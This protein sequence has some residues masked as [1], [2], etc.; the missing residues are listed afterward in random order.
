MLVNDLV[1]HAI[2][3]GLL[4]IHDVVALDVFFD[5]VDGL[6]AVLGQNFVDDRA[7]AQNFL[8]VQVDIGGLAAEAGHP[9]L[10]N[11][12]ARVGKREAFLGSAA[13]EQYGGDGSGLADAGSDHVG[14]H[15]LHGVV[16]GKTRGDRA[17]GRIDIELNVALGIFGLEKQHLG[18]G[19]IGDMVVNRRANK[20]DVLFEQ[21]GIDVIG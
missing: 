8:G 10:M 11:Q 2:V 9:R 1:N 18:G 14:L 7:H 19:Q 16:N 15:K 21:P 12:D 20:D 5:A 4:R 17:A 3:F 6:S 13:G